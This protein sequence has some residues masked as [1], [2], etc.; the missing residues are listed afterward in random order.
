MELKIMSL[1]SSHRD[2]ENDTKFKAS[3]AHIQSVDYLR[4]FRG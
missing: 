1:E 3:E 4:G 2:E